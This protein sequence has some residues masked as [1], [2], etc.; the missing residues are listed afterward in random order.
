MAVQTNSCLIFVIDNRNRRGKRSNID[1]IQLSLHHYIL[2]AGTPYFM[3]LT[4][5]QL[6]QLVMSNEPQYGL[7]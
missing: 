2:G 3:A 1:Y 6:W 4:K 5:H 7:P